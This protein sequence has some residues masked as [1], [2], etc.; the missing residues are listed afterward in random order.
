MA[1]AD[2]R[3]SV[4]INSATG[5]DIANFPDTPGSL[6]RLQTAS[7]ERILLALEESTGGTLEEKRDRLRQAIGMKIGG[8]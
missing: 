2:R 4:L 1:F 3:L 6:S 8:V 5:E 7:V